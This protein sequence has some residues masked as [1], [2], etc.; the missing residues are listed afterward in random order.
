M[1]TDAAAID[2][3]AIGRL[4][5]AMAFISGAD[6]PTAKALRKAAD[7]QA[8]ADIKKARQMFLALKP[9]TRA[10]AFAFLND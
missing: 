1:A 7:T 3:A 4:A 10:A 2:L 6:D 8:E 5:K 9:G